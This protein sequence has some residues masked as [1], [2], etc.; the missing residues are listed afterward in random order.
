[1]PSFFKSRKFSHTNNT[2]IRYFYFTRRTLGCL[3]GFRPLGQNPAG[4]NK[5]AE[6]DDVDVDDICN[7][8]DNDNDNNIN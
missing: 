1:M 8:H 7:N 4:E 3:L 2:T 6:D 5:Q